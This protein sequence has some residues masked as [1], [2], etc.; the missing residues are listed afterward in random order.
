MTEGSRAM[1]VMRLTKRVEEIIGYLLSE[2]WMSP[3]GGAA[4]VAAAAAAVSVPAAAEA[5]A[6]EAAAEV[7]AA[8]AAA[9]VA[10][11]PLPP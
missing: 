5:A 4:A 6:A 11:W 3:V 1:K 9:A 7:A 8:D 10:A 2:D